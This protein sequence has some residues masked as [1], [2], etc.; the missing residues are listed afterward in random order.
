MKSQEYLKEP[1]TR[2]LIPDGEGGF[3]AEI[4]EFPGCFSEGRTADEA[5]SNLEESV[6]AWIEACN[7]EGTPIPKPFMNQGYGG[8][9]ALRLP[10][11]LHRQI[12]RMAERDGTSINQLLVAAIGA[13]VGADK[14]YDR[15]GGHQP[16]YVVNLSI[17]TTERLLPHHGGSSWLNWTADT[18]RTTMPT[19]AAE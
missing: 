8:R 7:D 16:N 18:A 4:L 14:M 1:Y 11:S 9:I 17:A 3:S 19:I 2:I 10:K 15:I 6:L 12:A 5:M 13:W